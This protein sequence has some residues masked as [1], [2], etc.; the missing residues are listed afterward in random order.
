MKRKTTRIL[1]MV[2]SVVLLVSVLGVGAFAEGKNVK[3]YNNYLILGDSNAAGYGL[4]K[5]DD[6]FGYIRPQGLMVQGLYGTLVSQETGANVY[7]Y[8]R[9]GFR[10]EDILRLLDKN[11][12]YDQFSNTSIGYMGGTSAQEFAEL[13]DSVHADIAKADLITLNVGANDM[14]TQG[15]MYASYVMDDANLKIGDVTGYQIR[16]QL[17]SLLTG[18]SEGDLYNAV[19]TFFGYAYMAGV[20]PEVISAFLYG[21]GK[22]IMNFSSHWDQIIKQIREINPNCE[23]VAIGLMNPFHRCKL[24][25]ASLVEIGPLTDGNTMIANNY[26]QNESPYRDQYTYCD[27]TGAC[28]YVF[29]PRALVEADFVNELM[30]NVHPTLEGHRYYADRIEECISQGSTDT[31]V[32]WADHNVY[33]NATGAGTAVTNVNT[34]KVNEDTAITV[35]PNEGNH[36]S[37]IQVRDAGGNPVTVKK[38]INTTYYFKMPDSDVSVNVSFA[39]GEGEPDLS[40]GS[41]GNGGG[42]SSWEQGCPSAVFSDMTP[43][44]WYH[45]PVDYVLNKHIMTGTSATTFEPNSNLTRAMVCTILYAME[46]K[47]AVLTSAGFRDVSAGDWFVNPV[48]WAAAN[49]VVAGMG[50]GTFAPNANVTREQLATILRSYAVYK[51]KDVTPNGSLNGFADVADISFWATENITWAVGA[52]IITG[53]P[54]NLVDPKGTATRAE[55]ATMFKQFCTNVL[56]QA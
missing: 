42:H 5:G 51:G 33:L 55:A 22:G 24:T 40:Q 41:G 11:Y 44:S 2:L 13:Q 4:L 31:A 49:N 50:D 29:M 27:V 10:T 35:T 19:Y 36:C 54:G 45:G 18:Q 14:F 3:H 48:N 8:A 20:L 25:G 56:G 15:M 9:C 46:G 21:F 26:I 12:Q 37:S 17:V 32:T 38:A 7:N 47:P 30:L 6:Y 23:L 53:K 52:G 1:A 16:S 39:P 34:A 28:D 43:D